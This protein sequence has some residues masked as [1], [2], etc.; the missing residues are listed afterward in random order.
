MSV[1]IPRLREKGRK[2]VEDG[3]RVDE[4]QPR[5]L[6][7]LATAGDHSRR[8]VV[9]AVQKLRGR[10]ADEVGAELERTAQRG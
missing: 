8:H 10:L 9:V 6:H 2:R 7:P 4:V 1:L 3:A 5:L